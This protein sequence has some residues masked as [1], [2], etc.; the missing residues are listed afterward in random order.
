M[1]PLSISKRNVF[2]LSFFV[3]LTIEIILYWNFTKSAFAMDDPALINFFQNPET[4]TSEKIF[5]SLV[6]NR[7]RPVSDILQFITFQIFSNSYSAWLAL[8]LFVLA[9]TAAL[10]AQLIFKLHKSWLLAVLG[11]FLLVSSRFVLYQVTQANG[12]MEGVA[13]FLFV[14]LVYLAL[15]DWKIA[16]PL[17]VFMT[18][19]AFFLLVMTHE[20]FQALVLAL[21]AWVLLNTSLSMK[22]KLGMVGGFTLPVVALN[23]VKIFWAIPLAI[24]AG[25]KTELGLTW[26]AVP[27]FL[28]TV[29]LNALGINFGP[30][31]LFGLTIESQDF[32]QALSS[33]LV[34]AVTAAAIVFAVTRVR[35]RSEHSGR[36]LLITAMFLAGLVAPIVSTIRVESRWI[37]SLF[38]VCILIVTQFLARNSRN[39][40][41]KFSITGV[42]IVAL[43]SLYL[44]LSFLTNSDNL[45]FRSHQI[46]AENYIKD[47]TPVL[48]QSV[49][50]GRHIQIVSGCTGDYPASWFN[51][52]LNANIEKQLKTLITCADSPTAALETIQISWDESSGK[53]SIQN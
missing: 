5:P 37:T 4:S 1:M 9:A 14:W 27:I 49:T 47:W 11:G 36:I 7:F 44:N 45:Y 39:T 17:T 16:R 28:A 10:L 35:K 22:R 19:V 30:N 20:R 38:I 2:A 51:S 53:L 50:Q 13:L 40:K 42:T 23:A 3:F 33:Y 29:F 41:K 32:G 6:A 18:P 15:D 21:I 43:T 31:Y 25:S 8:N 26:G 34:A 12:L 46:T 52:L 48:Q 24:G